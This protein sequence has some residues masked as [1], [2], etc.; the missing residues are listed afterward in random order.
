MTAPAATIRPAEAG[1][2]PRFT[3]LAGAVGL[4]EPAEVAAV[5]GNLRDHLAAGEDAP[6]VWSLLA[7][8]PGGE[9]RGVAYARPEELTDGTWNLLLLAIHPDHHRR[10]HA[11]ALIA[12]T[13]TELKARGG[14]LLLVETLGTP[15]FTGVRDLYRRRGFGEEARVRDYYFDR[16]DKVTFRKPLR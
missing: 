13:E 16:G 6:E 14:R 9:V 11:T 7:G 4:F 2:E 15:D 5:A 12:H 1:D 3:R 10:G 8:P